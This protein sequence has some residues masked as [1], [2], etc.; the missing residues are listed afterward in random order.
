[1]TEIFKSTKK[2]G[3]RYGRRLRDMFGIIENEQ[4]KKQ[5]CP[6]CRAVKVKR[7]SVGI[8]FCSRCSA[9]FTGKAYSV[10]K[11]VT[12]EESKGKEVQE[13]PVENPVEV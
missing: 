6:Y 1:M 3:A 9:K 2:F 12:F 5:T 10:E 11:K 4:R 7:L 13:K 8:W